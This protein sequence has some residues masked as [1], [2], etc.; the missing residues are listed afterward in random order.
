MARHFISKKE[1]KAIHTNASELGLSLPP[2]DMEVEEVRKDKCYFIGGKPCLFQKDIMIPT[3]IIL[4]ELKP[5]SRTITV[6]DGAVPHIL[7]GA[8]VFA[9]G[10]I[11]V[12]PDVSEGSVVYVRDSKGNYLAVGKASRSGSDIMKDKKG[13]AVKLLHYPNDSL[14]QEFS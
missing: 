14:I 8:N 1:A 5:E 2:G 11:D 3:I 7:R 4:N 9:Q 10:I 13:E 12:S 6:D